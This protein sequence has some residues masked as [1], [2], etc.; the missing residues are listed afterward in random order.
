MAG[1]I[2]DPLSGELVKIAQKFESDPKIKAL[3]YGDP[4]TAEWLWNKYVGTPRNP[5]KLLTQTEI[6][7]YKA[8]IQEFIDNIG[9]PEGAIGQLFKLPKALMR[10][11]PESSF[12]SQEMSNAT[13]FRQK[14]LKESAIEI[15]KMVDGLYKMMLFHH[16]YHV[17]LR[18][19][20]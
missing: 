13:S 15:N 9:R 7:K 17:V 8:G 19:Y 14:H 18:E 2:R 1:C 20:V 5:N 11:L 3:G 10:K 12:F 6:K 16:Q 4:A